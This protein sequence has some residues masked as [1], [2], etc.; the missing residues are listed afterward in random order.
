MRDPDA[1]LRQ[2]RN[3]ETTDQPEPGLALTIPPPVMPAPF[4]WPCTAEPW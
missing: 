4:I 3:F 1:S 2:G